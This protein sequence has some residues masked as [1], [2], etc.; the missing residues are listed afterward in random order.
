MAGALLSTLAGLPDYVA[1]SKLISLGSIAA[2][3]F[4]VLLLAPGCDLKVSRRSVV[5]FARGALLNCT[6]M[7]L[8]GGRLKSR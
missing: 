7:E 1:P 5:P 4:N 3:V 6:K 2:A 8:S